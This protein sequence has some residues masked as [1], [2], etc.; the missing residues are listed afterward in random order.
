MVSGRE[1]GQESGQLPYLSEEH[2]RL[3]DSS[4]ADSGPAARRYPAAA[5]TVAD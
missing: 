4:P 3:E 1:D 5:E 2:C